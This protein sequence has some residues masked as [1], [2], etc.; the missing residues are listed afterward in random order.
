MT[1]TA[2]GTVVWFEVP[3]EDSA[4]ARSFYGDLFG[5]H[6]DELPDQDYHTTLAG[7]GAIHG[8]PGQKGLLT[9]F[10]VDDIDAALTRV[11]SLGGKAGDKQEIPDVGF[12]AQ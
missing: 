10:G 5:W 6:F 3:A 12:S 4:R 8:A 1:E 7:G 11:E 9:Y 2:T